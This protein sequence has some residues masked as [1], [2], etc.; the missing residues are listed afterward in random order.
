MNYLINRLSVFVFIGSAFFMVAC[1]S[2]HKDANEAALG[3]MQDQSLN[4]KIPVYNSIREY[5]AEINNTIQEL[6]SRG[7]VTVERDGQNYE[8]RVS[9]KDGDP[10]M[11]YTQTPMG[12]QQ[13]WF[14]LKNRELIMLRELGREGPV[15]YESEFF[16]EGEDFLVGITR[17]AK[18]SGNLPNRAFKKYE[19]EEGVVDYRILPNDAF[20]SAMEFLMGR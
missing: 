4:S 3:L 9:Y 20:A 11:I 1:Q 13:T 18:E 14:Y 10:V 16:Y 7:P 2:G 8:V 15:Y 12:N 17:E 19:P 6:E 5:T